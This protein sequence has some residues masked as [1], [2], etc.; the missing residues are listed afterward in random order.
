MIHSANTIVLFRDTKKCVSMCGIALFQ[1]VKSLSG[2]DTFNCFKKIIKFH[3]AI[4][5]YVI[6]ISIGVVTLCI[7]NKLS[8]N[9]TASHLNIIFFHYPP[10]KNHRHDAC[11]MGGGCSRS[12]G[13]A[14]FISRNRTRQ[15][16]TWSCDIRLNRPDSRV[17]SAGF[18]QNAVIELIIGGNGQRGFQEKLK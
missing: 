16:I 11:R 15:L 6:W 1:Y 14:V 13:S 4:P 8:V 7:P 17:T 5:P 10:F 3:L 12:S 9:N 2:L 18:N